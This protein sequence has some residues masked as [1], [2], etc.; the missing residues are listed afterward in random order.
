MTILKKTLKEALQWVRRSQMKETMLRRHLV[1]SP[2][3][4]PPPLK[5]LSEPHTI[6]ENDTDYIHS[7]E[8]EITNVKRPLFAAE[9]RV[10]QAE[11]R[12]EVITQEVNALAELLI[13]QLD[14]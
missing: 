7:L 5:A 1:N 12:E 3:P 8:N 6:Q 11:Q 14:D 10:V 9:A 13:C 4:P 2:P